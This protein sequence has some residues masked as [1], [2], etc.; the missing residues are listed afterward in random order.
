MLEVFEVNF[1][2]K[3]IV[4]MPTK[5][6][7]DTHL[8]LWDPNNLRYPWLDEIPLLNK[9][10]LL[11]D[12]DDATSGII[13]EKMVFVQC[14]CLFSQCEQEAEWVTRLAQADERIQGIVPWAPLEKGEGAKDILERFSQNQLVKGIRRIIQFEPDDGFCLQPGFI[15]GVR[16]L[17]EYNM[18]F[19]LCISHLQLKNTIKLVQLCPQV[20][21]IL[22]HIGKPN[23]KDQ[24]FEPW[25]K[26]LKELATLKNVCCKMSGL[27]TE[28]DHKIWKME[29][30]KP[31]V[32][33]ALEA[34]GVER[35]MFGG[36]WPVA[37]QAAGY[38]VWVD[39]LDRALAGLSEN[40]LQ[41][42]YHDNALKF[43][44]L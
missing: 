20:H 11:N 3:L 28:A 38:S 19:D 40:E 29:D 17:A 16:M 12:Y 43:Y 39:A 36:D 30:L 10:Y 5:P 42:I 27:V 44:K 33:Y 8:H 2:T 13:V 32:V 41:K 25:K 24:L 31:Y 21:F 7:I 9:P 1:K 15:R 26:E 6:I 18:S 37:T 35:I 23:I 4:E 22:D 34:F 14:E